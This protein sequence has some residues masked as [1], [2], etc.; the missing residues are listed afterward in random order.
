MRFSS[1][2]HDK[3][4]RQ[5]NHFLKIPNGLGNSWVDDFDDHTPTLRNIK[6]E[7][8][9]LSFLSENM[10]DS[11]NEKPQSKSKDSRQSQFLDNS[12]REAKKYDD[13]LELEKNIKKE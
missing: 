3:I 12:E 4:P 11:E 8:S 6:A 10:Q 2:K 7:E 13:N 1:L 9:D 5:K